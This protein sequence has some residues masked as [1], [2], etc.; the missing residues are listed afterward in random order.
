[1]NERSNTGGWNRLKKTV[2]QKCAAVSRRRRARNQGSQTC[3]SL[4][5]M[6]ESNKEEEE[7]GN[8]WKPAAVL[9]KYVSTLLV[10][11]F[12]RCFKVLSGD[13]L[14]ELRLDPIP[15]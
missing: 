11:R 4:D 1:M 15:P 9:G 13:D 14:Q 3:V 8:R 12:C 7:G 10:L 5:S 6:I 2:L